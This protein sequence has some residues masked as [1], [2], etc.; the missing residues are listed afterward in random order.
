LLI[1]S[2]LDGCSQDD[3]EIDGCSQENFT[4]LLYHISF[5]E[6]YHEILNNHKPPTS[7]NVVITNIYYITV[8]ALTMYHISLSY[9]IIMLIYYIVML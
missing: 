6:D 3:R 2:Y 9:Y 7:N 8:L 5:V 4:Y 1:Y